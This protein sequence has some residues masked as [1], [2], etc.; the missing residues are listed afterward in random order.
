MRL[1]TIDD[2]AT[3]GWEPLLDHVASIQKVYNLYKSRARSRRHLSM[4]ISGDED[5]PPGLHASELCTC[6]RQASYSLKAVKKKSDDRSIDNNM[7]M[8]FDI[9]HAVHALLQNDFHRMCGYSDGRILFED[10]VRINDSTGGVALTYQIRSS[11]DG[12]F[13]FYDYDANPYLRCGLEIKSM[14]DAE[15]EKYKT[16]DKKHLLQGNLYQKCLD[17]PLMW[18]LYYNK[19]NSNYTAPRAP[20]VQKF[21]PNI[22]NQIESRAVQI[23]DLTNK[24][25]LPER[26]EGRHCSWCPYSTECAPAYNSKYRR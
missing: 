13:T 23:H 6:I 25:L 14:S 16:P 10:E 11:S 7:L 12:V 19:S 8:R 20:F 17:L 24:G 4:T 3:P 5:R 18:Y 15:F 26:E 1:L 21:N 22:W 9:G 2:L